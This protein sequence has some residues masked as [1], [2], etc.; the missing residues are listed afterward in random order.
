MDIL[1]H[2]A[3][4]EAAK[5]GMDDRQGL[6]KAANERIRQVTDELSCLDVELR[7]LRKQHKVRADRSRILK[8]IPPTDLSP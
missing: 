6:L 8:R 7:K 5:A 2:K 3:A 1:A 4:I